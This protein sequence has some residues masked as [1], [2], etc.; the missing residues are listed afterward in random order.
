[1]RNSF[2]N[3]TPIIQ[4]NCII[5]GTNKNDDILKGI[6][7]G[8][9]SKYTETNKDQ[10]LIIELSECCYVLSSYL[11][12]WCFDDRIYTYSFCVSKDGENWKTIFENRIAKG[13]DTIFIGEPIKYIKMNG[14]NSSNPNLH[15]ISFKLN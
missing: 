13:N 2:C 10:N 7:N 1:M 8:S 11:T 12:F 6:S 4:A 14:Y 3:V 9:S 5:H 15:L